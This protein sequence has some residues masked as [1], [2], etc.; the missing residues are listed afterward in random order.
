MSVKRQV[1]FLWQSSWMV[2]ATFAGGAL[3]AMVHTVARKMGPQEYSV[4]V[5][6]LRLLIIMGIPATALQT[7]F[8]RQAAAVTND[9]EQR[10]LIAT[11]RA[12][13]L[14]T[15]L[16]WLVLAAGVLAA[17]RP[18]SNLLKISNPAALYITLVIGLIG[19][20]IPMVKGLLQGQHRFGGLGWLQITDGVGRFGV[21]LLVILVFR[22]KAAAAMFAALVGQLTT[23][24]IGAW[25]TRSTWR[26]RPA[27]AFDWRKWLGHALPLTLGLGTVLAVSSIDMLFVQSLFTDTRQTALYGG[28]MLTGFAIVQLIAPVALVMFAWV[29]QSTARSQRSDSLAMTLGATLLFG[30]LAAVGCTLLPQLPL[31]L[32]YLA[33]PEMWRA[34]PLVPRFAWALLPLTLA[35]VLVQNILARGRFRAVPWLV[36]VPPAYAAALCL[37][38]PALARMPHFDAFTRIIETLGAASTL[39]CLVAAWFSRDPKTVTVSDP[40]SEPAP[41]VSGRASSPP[42]Q[43]GGAAL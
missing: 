28:A 18:L 6:L 17:T 35:N 24:S 5:T 30:V 42:A 9:T 10:Q 37:Q 3:M 7:I 13:L 1:S 31:R 40:V 16:L 27:T 41:A 38:A 26:P 14:G 11:T 23:V 19:P 25:L 29:A 20:W 8:A 32:M 39:L 22:G 15:F 12:V 34:A 2:I 4:F 36:L 33:N 21:M 43:K